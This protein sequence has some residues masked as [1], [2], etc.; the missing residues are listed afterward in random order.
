MASTRALTLHVFSLSMNAS[1]SSTISSC[2]MQGDTG[3][4]SELGGTGS[5]GL[6]GQ[7]GLVR[8][9]HS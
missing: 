3:H 6:A 1:V 4:N 2:G 8:D 7:H 9:Q 5:T